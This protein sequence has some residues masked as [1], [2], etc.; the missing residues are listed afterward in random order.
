MTINPE[1]YKDQVLYHHGIKGM[2]WGQRKDAVKTSISKRRTQ[3]KQLRSIKKKRRQ[4]DRLRSTLSDKELDRRVKRLEKEERLHTLTKKNVNTGRTETSK[5]LK[6]AGATIATT[7]L[8]GAGTYAIATGGGAIGQKF[9]K[10]A[11]LMGALA[12]KK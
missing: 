7:A 10:V 11:G 3:N 5:I 4:A 8:V 1:F 2:K 9:P 6:R 12:K